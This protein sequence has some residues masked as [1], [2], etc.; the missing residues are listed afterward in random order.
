MPLLK[1]SQHKEKALSFLT[2]LK[3]DWIVLLA[4]IFIGLIP[5]LDLLISS[6][7]VIDS[8]EAIVGLMAKHMLEGKGIPAFYYGQHYMG[9]LE[10]ITVA[11]FFWL[12]GISN[13]ALRL[14][15]LCYFVVL[16]PIVYLIGYAILNRS[17]ARLTALLTSLSPAAFIE[18][19]TKPRG[20]FIEIVVISALILYLVLKEIGNSNSI[21]TVRLCWIAFL[22]GLGWW[23]NNQ[24]LYF[25]LPTFLALGFKI[26][27]SGE[28][29]S[30]GIG[31]FLKVVTKLGVL[32]IS[33]FLIGS[34]P[35]W[36]H[37]LNH[38]FAS[39]GIFNVSKDVTKN[40]QGLFGEALPIILGARRFWTVND[41]FTY[42]TLT[43]YLLYGS[44]LIFL[45]YSLKHFGNAQK[46]YLQWFGQKQ[47]VV[48]FLL[49]CVLSILSIFCVSAFG[50]LST[51]PRYLL[52]L[53]PPLCTLIAFSLVHCSQLIKIS[54]VSVLLLVNAASYYYKD[55]ALP[56]EP[57][58][59][60]EDRV[61][62]EHNEL[63]TWLKEKDIKYIRTNYWIGYRLA[64]ETKEAVT[65]SMFGNPQTV[66]IAEY[67]KRD[68][69]EKA[70]TPLLVTD[71]VFVEVRSALQNMGYSFK[72]HHV[73][74]YTIFYDIA[75]PYDVAGLVQIPNSKIELS[76]SDSE[77]DLKNILDNRIETRWGSGKNQQKGMFLKVTFKEPFHIKAIDY[78]IGHWITDS[79]RKLS[80]TCRDQSGDSK[81]LLSIEQ[82]STIRQFFEYENKDMLIYFKDTICREL[83]F[84]QD[85]EDPVFDW[86]IAE[87]RLFY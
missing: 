35:F 65:F 67:E 8:D 44:L 56:G 52:P 59:V 81:E 20:G 58:V 23:T 66:R 63:I 41:V 87:L 51:A 5:R 28:V 50:S 86:S 48:L 9:S 2:I 17:T 1:H 60:N 19:S 40:I 34:A 3:Q 38:D 18:W 84:N 26:A 31:V 30:Q 37:N 77:K 80:I 61:M 57:F 55:K 83:I 33:F 78:A 76:S 64:F 74:D 46:G 21:N 29:K 36:I 11:V 70:V 13:F 82:I 42:G 54:L 69:L 75:A 12:F 27:V 39:F 62:K 79:P 68:A 73:K 7:W 72:T 45:L 4:I 15:P 43:V 32:S 25:A 22:F 85:G 47:S 16:I 49:L 71:S 14:A 24:I 10:P 6:D 53:Y